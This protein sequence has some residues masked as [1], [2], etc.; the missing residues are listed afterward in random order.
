MAEATLLEHLLQTGDA[1]DL[2][3]VDVTENGADSG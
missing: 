1:A 2:R 3:A